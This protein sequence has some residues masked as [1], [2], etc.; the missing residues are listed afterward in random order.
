M[1]QPPIYQH[2]ELDGSD[3]YWKGSSVGILLIHGFTATSVEV[4]GLATHLHQAGYTVAGPLLPGHGT[5]PEEMNRYS[6]KDWANAA[7]QQ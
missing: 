7:E 2:P 1:N 5:S 3:F 4:R 6:W